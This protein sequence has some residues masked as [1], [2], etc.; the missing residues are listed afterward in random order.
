MRL[1][2]STLDRVKAYTHIYSERVSYTACA[3]CM[4]I[5]K[6]ASTLCTFVYT[7]HTLSLGGELIL[8]N[9]LSA[10]T[11]IARIWR[12]TVQ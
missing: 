5:E 11:L 6:E 3:L 1:T 7:V 2:L 12:H 10:V 8:A 4:I 9:S